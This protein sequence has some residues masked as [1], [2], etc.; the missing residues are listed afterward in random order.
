[1][2]LRLQLLVLGTLG[3]VAGGCRLFKSQEPAP[4]R[5]AVSEELLN[6][7][8][9]LATARSLP[10]EESRRWVDAINGGQSSVN[11]F[12]SELLSRPSFTHEVAPTLLLRNWF[13]ILLETATGTDK[14]VLK[15]VPAAQAG[16]RPV[17]Y[18]HQP[19]KAEQAVPVKPWWAPKEEVLVCEEAYR[20]FVFT[21]PPQKDNP[22]GRD[23]SG[24]MSGLGSTCGCGPGLMRC[25]RDEE[26]L[27]TVNRSLVNEVYQS[28]GYM[29]SHDY[30]LQRI[31]TAN[32]SFRDRNA[33]RAYQIWRVENREIDA[34]PDLSD[35]PEQGR[36]APRHESLPGQHAG[37]LTTPRTAFI[38]DVHRPRIKLIYQ[39][40]WCIEPDSAH[41]TTEGV[42]ALGE[43]DIQ[44]GDGWQ[45]LAAMP[46][47]TNCHA[48]LDYGMQFLAGY[49]DSR[50][51][52]HFSTSRV[53]QG[54]GPFYG[55]GIGD[56]RGEGLQTPLGFA[57]LAT[58]QKE[59][60]ACMMS[61][62]TRHVFSHSTTTLDQV[63]M[64]ETYSHSPTMRELMRTAL[65]RYSE[66]WLAGPDTAPQ[67]QVPQLQV[68]T[69]ETIAVPQALRDSLDVNCTYCHDADHPQLDLTRGE[70]SRKAVEQ[71]LQEVAFTRMPRTPGELSPAERREMVRLLVELRWSQP[72]Q[73][74][75]AMEY[76]ATWMRALPVQEVRPVTDAIYRSAG[77]SPDRTLSKWALTEEETREDLVQ[78]T[79]G[80]ATMVGLEALRACKAAGNQ[81]EAL[82]RCLERATAIQ[83]IVRHVEK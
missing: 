14:R 38:D 1:M 11:D 30:P 51:V 22:F 2:K 39:K 75:T 81:G 46:I 9:Q 73:R 68:A 40:L 77:A 62:V 71:M 34:L 42:L 82:D 80:F 36:W 45:K 37:V 78:L 27:E 76:F 3:V 25:Y 67:A 35:W 33:E 83:D 55:R 50:L 53:K 58:Q 32:E 12:V 13:P 47:C 49:P 21:E 31:F 4:A 44:R 63:A 23:C 10:A 29:V 20:P 54:K 43:A 70:L 56:L 66:R 26:Q 74:H 61:N 18:L 65:L 79:P 48:R 16:G 6:S 5:P 17:F 41:V 8:A 24:W 59:F 64:R 28:I 15:Q 52:Q 69:G 72:E 7:M 19:C 57:T 60:D